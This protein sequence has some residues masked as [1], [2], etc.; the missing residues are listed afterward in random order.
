MS[1]PKTNA[2][3]AAKH[4]KVHAKVSVKRKAL[5]MLK[6]FHHGDEDWKTKSHASRVAWA[7]ERALESKP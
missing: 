7:I 2:E 3:R 5:A 6:S 1:K 4:L